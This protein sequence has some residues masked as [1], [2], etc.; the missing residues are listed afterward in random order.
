MSSSPEVL[1]LDETALRRWDEELVPDDIAYAAAYPGPA[2]P[3]CVHTVYVPVPQFV[4]DVV[5]QWGL[6]ARQ[7]MESYPE[8]WHDL[9]VELAGVDPGELEALTLAKLRAEPIEDLRIDFEDGFRAHRGTEADDQEE[10]AHAV[11]AAG[12]VAGMTM[13]RSWGLRIRSLA[14]ATRGRGLRTLDLFLGELLGLGP[15]PAGF[16]ITLPKANSSSRN[17]SSVRSPRRRVAPSSDLIRN[18]TNAVPA[19]RPRAVPAARAAASSSSSGRA[20]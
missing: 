17:S 20:P 6:F 5:A 8:Q 7:A 13:P 9:L 4:D 14:G 19:L 16:V 1:V 3:G 2:G 10:D 18:P 15:L 11:R 12:V